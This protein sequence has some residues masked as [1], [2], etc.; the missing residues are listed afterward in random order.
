MDCKGVARKDDAE[1]YIDI[2]S[3]VLHCVGCGIESEY[4]DW[5]HHCHRCGGVYEGGEIWQGMASETVR[6]DDV[7][8][9]QA[10][11]IQRG[12]LETTF[13]GWSSCRACRKFWNYDIGYLKSGTSGGGLCESCHD[14]GRKKMRSWFTLKGRV[15]CCNWCGKCGGSNRKV[16]AVVGGTY[17][18]RECCDWVGSQRQ[19]LA[20]QCHPILY[21][22]YYR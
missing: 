11:G 6:M 4:L 17:I 3:G 2:A 9:F 1:M 20:L 18:C 22:E 19:M 16:V 12:S 5:E 10:S 15:S 14:I 21:R 8:W 7:V 13:L